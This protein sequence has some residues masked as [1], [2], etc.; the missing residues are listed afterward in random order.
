M[1]RSLKKSANSDSAQNPYGHTLCEFFSYEEDKLTT[2]VVINVGTNTET[3]SIDRKKFMHVHPAEQY[4]FNNEDENVNI[5]GNQQGGINKRSFI[6]INIQVDK[7]TWTK[8]RDFYT[9][10]QKRT[11]AKFT[12]PLSRKPQNKFWG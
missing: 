10:T 3:G 2:D 9:T 4:Y 1:A 7:N 8:A 11:D 5:A 6:T 12:K